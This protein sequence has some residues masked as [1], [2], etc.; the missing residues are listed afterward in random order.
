[1]KSI[2]PSSR[3]NGRSLRSQMILFFM[4][5][6]AALFLVSTASLYLVNESRIGGSAYTSV[7][8]SK[9][10]LENIAEI[11]TGLYQIIAE[12]SYLL[13]ETDLGVAARSTSTIKGL[14]VNVDQRLAAAL[15]LIEQP[16]E[17]NLINKT[18]ALWKEYRKTLQEEIVPAST[19][20]DR[21]KAR[22]LMTG[23]QAQRL[24]SIGTLAASLSS[25][26]RQTATTAEERVSSEIRVLMIISILAA[27]IAMSLL[28]LICYALTTSVTRPLGNCTAFVNSLADGR[29]D[30]RLAVAGPT[31]L[32]AL[33]GAINRMAEFLHSKISR[34]SSVSETLASIENN[35]EKSSRH[36]AHSARLQEAAIEQSLPAI[37]SI[38]LSVK[39]VS[40]KIEK[41]A[42]SAAETASSTLQ[43]TATVEEIAMSADKLGDSFD[44]VSSSITEMAASIKE[45]GSSIVNLLEAS[46]ET[47]SSIA[48][49]DATIKQVEKNALD[50]STISTGVRDDAET[51]KRAVEEA[52]AGMQAIRNSSQ[53]TA[54]V[55]E[56]LSL[57]AND[58][59]TILSVIDEVAEQTNLLA[60]N[61][62]IIAAQAGEHGK[63]FAVVADEIRELSERTSSS[64]REIATVIRGV[65]EE[66]RR[67]VEAINKAEVSIAD[68]ER[69]SHHSG[70]ALEKI[71]SGVQQASTQVD[72]IA[73]A[74]LEQAHG[75][76][77][78][79]EAME[80][81]AEMV[82]HIANSAAEHTQSSEQIARAM[83]RMKDLAIHVR[84]ST[85]EQSQ[86]SCLISDATREVLD[87]I[88]QVRESGS[89]QELNRAKVIAAL[90]NI[91]ASTASNVE[92][93]RVMEDS[94]VG[95]SKQVNLLEKELSD[96][97]L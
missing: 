51:G 71:V 89:F 31:E 64:T 15:E 73:R 72:R 56:N 23:I 25:G 70:A 12:V 33:T 2:P 62:T 87:I 86:T 78:I 55:I 53:I 50:A 4:V 75:S 11:K 77:S 5:A 81:V 63:G 8:N 95:L 14:S 52:I 93:V 85:H 82:E 39:N 90:K 7:N 97:K 46:G 20:G 40:E 28:A 18:D 21:L 1:M 57:R 84:S 36:V 19:T 22:T 38:Q 44:E 34:I 79:K 49:M 48:Q 67:A 35:I 69:L 47:A 91:Q 76:H 24:A 58:I 92:N 3:A 10:A 74:T 43:M 59:G 68:G 17:R 41:L 60:L 80:S 26:L 37:E 42:S 9:N 96:F 16:A 66:T 45:I 65:Q 29:F 13:A 54:E 6:S 94:L 61:A 88:E 27:V 30:T 83:E 32:T